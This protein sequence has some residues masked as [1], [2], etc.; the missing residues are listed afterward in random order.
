MCVP[1][2]I[3]TGISS[4]SAMRRTQTKIW[5]HSSSIDGHP[6]ASPRMIQ[7]RVGTTTPSSRRVR[8][9]PFFERA[10]ATTPTC[11]SVTQTSCLLFLVEEITRQE[12]LPPYD[13]CCRRLGGLDGN[14]A[15]PDS[16]GRY[17]PSGGTGR[18]QGDDQIGEPTS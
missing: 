15:S 17:P 7:A 13:F 5:V 18:L 2:H 14:R 6:L 9:H 16:S 8:S 10:R 12:G 4:T 1:R 11:W 3:G